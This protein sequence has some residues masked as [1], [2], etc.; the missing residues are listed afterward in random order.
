LAVVL[1]WALYSISLSSGLALWLALVV[2]AVTLVYTYA[3]GFQKHFGKSQANAEIA[4]TAI[5]LATYAAYEAAPMASSA[6]NFTATAATLVGSGLVAYPLFYIAFKAITSSFVTTLGYA[7]ESVHTKLSSKIVSAFAWL[8][9]QQKAA[10]NDKSDFAKMF[11]HLLN[12]AVLAAALAQALPVVSAQITSNF[13][14]DAF[15]IAF[16]SINGFVLLGRLFSH[17]GGATMAFISSITT[18]AAVGYYVNTVSSSLVTAIVIG[19]FAANIVG[20]VLAPLVYLQLAKLFAPVTAKLAPIVI[21]AFEA[22]W[23]V[24]K[25]LWV[26]VGRQFKFILA[27]LQPVLA[28]VARTWQTITAQV[29]RVFGA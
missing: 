28:A 23:S 24:Y 29:G 27:F 16:V 25:A 1:A 2:G 8:R 26:A 15:I 9:E 7:L 18:L 11:G 17:Y 21:G 3:E 19:L 10:F 12:A 6:G 4:V 20:G 13:W 14:V 5:A 22:L